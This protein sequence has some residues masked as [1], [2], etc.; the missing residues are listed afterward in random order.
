[1]LDVGLLEVLGVDAAHRHPPRPHSRTRVTQVL[2]N[3]QIFFY[4]I[5]YFWYEITPHLDPAVNAGLQVGPRLVKAALSQEQ[6]LLLRPHCTSRGSAQ[7]LLQG[8]ATFEKI[9]K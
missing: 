6:L 4:P 9:F 1:M 5:I 3:L 8:I 2:L 7:G